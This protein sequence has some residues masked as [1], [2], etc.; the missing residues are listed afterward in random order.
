MSVLL[1]G[2]ILLNSPVNGLYALF[3]YILCNSFL[4]TVHTDFYDMVTLESRF[5]THDLILLLGVTC[6]LS[7]FLY[8]FFFLSVLSLSLCSLKSVFV[9]CVQLVFWQ[10]LCLNTRC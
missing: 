9:A 4:K 2:Q 5:F 6:L 10:R 1:Q 3:L 7:G 8:C